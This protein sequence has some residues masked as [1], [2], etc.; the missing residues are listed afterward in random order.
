[1]SQF[2]QIRV[3]RF[4]QHSAV[5]AACLGLALLVGCRQETPEK[6]ESQPPAEVLAKPA[7]EKLGKSQT[8]SGRDVLNRMVEAYRKA[9]SYADAGTV[10]LLAE[11]GGKKV[12]DDSASFSLT[13]VRPN[14]VRLQVYLATV[15]CDGKKLYAAIGDLPGQ[16]LI[17]DA[18]KRLTLKTLFADRMLAS[19]LTQGIAGAMPQVMLLLADD[20]MKALLHDAEEPVLSEPGQI[21]DRSC[22]RVQIKRPDGTATFWIDQETFVL[23]RIVLPTD[24]IRQ[25]I[26]EQQPVDHVSAIAEITGAQLNGKV[27]PKAFAFEVPKNAEIVKFFI[28]PSPALLLSK[29]V[30]DFKFFDLDGK[31]VTPQSLSGKI[32]VL[33]FWASWCGP[34][35]QSLPNLEKVYE[36]YKDNPKVAF[37]AVSVDQ[38]KVENRELLKLFEDLKVKVPI[39]RDPEHSAAA[40]KF[41]GIPT[42][43]IL[44]PD[45]VVQ[46]CEQGGN[47]RLA[48]L[49][50]DKLKK[51]VAGQNIFDQPLKEYQEQLNRYA[52][53]V[54][55]AA[56]EGELGSG[57][58][59]T[60]EGKPA[61]AKTAPRNEPT[62]FKLTSLW[63]C[64]GVKSPGSVLVLSD[65]NRPARLAVVENWKSVAEVGLD[66]KLI[67]MHKLNLADSE[68]VGSLRSAVGA[69]GKRWLVAFLP[70]QQR[71]HVL[72]ENWNV[73]ASYPEN[74]LKNPHSGIGDV[75]LGDLDGDGKLKMFVSYWGVVGVQGVSLDG[76]RLWDNRSLSNVRSMAIGAPDDKG[77][78]KLYCTN[79][80][81]SLVVLDAQGRRQGEVKVL[82]QML[83]WIAAADLRGDGQPLWCAMVSPKLGENLA[84]GLSP[85][86]KELWRYPLPS[87]IQ[88]Q[89]IEPIIAGKLTRSGPG[90]WILPG[91]D[92]SIHVVSADGKPWDKFNSGLILQGLATAEIV[93]QPVLVVSSSNG[94]EAWKVDQSEGK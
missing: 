69:D 3:D 22:Y 27:D 58:L 47:P 70:W 77:H 80:M 24:Q 8:S 30:P 43:F 57:E 64:A 44:S 4:F 29:K 33:D 66:G 61:E 59:M 14:Q 46:D 87:G 52:K 37:Y 82:D 93:G 2:L 55:K 21:G 85:D 25:D 6:T 1:M 42:T 7:A 49:L 11:G 92:G 15:V 67:A 12:I 23:R 31:P 60:E 86:G 9:S 71:C 38:P 17:K 65:K 28:P 48:E 19:A 56:V 13:L 89:P 51:L 16:V 10:H 39:L 90:Q 72:D 84:V 41:T 53:M 45:G 20:P 68:A 75:Q 32:A 50:P 73:V 5:L 94:L 36:Q 62:H 18:P 91:P 34:C 88:P 81:G 26:S 54:E 78:R 40:L 63:K 83:Q 35:K 76:K 74:A 79:L